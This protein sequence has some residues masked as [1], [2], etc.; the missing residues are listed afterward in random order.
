MANQEDA[1][2]IYWRNSG[3]KVDCPNNQQIFTKMNERDVIQVANL[4]K[5]ILTE[6]LRKQ[7]I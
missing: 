3:A 6:I 5:T 4:Y 7:I 2:K 1:S